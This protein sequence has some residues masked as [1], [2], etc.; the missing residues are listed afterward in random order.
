MFH[1]L[2]IYM[3]ERVGRVDMV[4]DSSIIT[5][6]DVGMMLFIMMAGHQKFIK[7]QMFMGVSW[8]VIVSD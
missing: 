1:A 3:L 2:N 4:E 8:F 6:C 5:L 7:V